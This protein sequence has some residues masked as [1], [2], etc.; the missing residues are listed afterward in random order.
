MHQHQGLAPSGHQSAT[1]QETWL[2]ANTPMASSTESS[3]PSGAR[4][5]LTADELA[6]ALAVEVYDAE[7]KTTKLGGLVQGRRSLL[8]FIRHFCK[9]FLGFR[10]FLLI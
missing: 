1:R 2:V 9:L 6:R 4:T 3:D 7:G 10:T 5:L 8:V